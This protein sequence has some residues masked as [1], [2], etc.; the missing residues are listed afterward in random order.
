VNVSANTTAG[1]LKVTIAGEAAK[2]I[3]WIAFIR[4][5][6]SVE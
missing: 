4:E 2:T 6:K 5:T 3:K 1:A